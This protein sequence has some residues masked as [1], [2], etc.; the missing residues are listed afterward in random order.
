MLIQIPLKYSFLEG[1]N[2]PQLEVT[3]AKS[4][5]LLNHVLFERDRKASSNVSVLSQ[6][7]ESSNCFMLYWI[8]T[9]TTEIIGATL[10]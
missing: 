5:A 7:Q 3:I 9:D 4:S 2:K 1:A 6:G 8:Q 10:V